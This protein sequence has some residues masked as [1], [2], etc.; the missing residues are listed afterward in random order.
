[1][2]D[3]GYDAPKHGAHCCMAIV[4]CLTVHFLCVSIN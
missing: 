4:L 2:P 3:V 1:M